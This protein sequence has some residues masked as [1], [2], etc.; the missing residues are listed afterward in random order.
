MK[1]V[2]NQQPKNHGCCLTPR[3]VVLKI[4]T[5]EQA[6]CHCLAIKEAMLKEYL[7]ATLS[8]LSLTSMLLIIYNMQNWDGGKCKS[9]N[10]FLENL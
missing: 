8:L 6:W 5:G 7:I 9:N 2:K 4:L 10:F 1:R 3:A